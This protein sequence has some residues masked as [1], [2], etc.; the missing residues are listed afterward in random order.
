VIPTVPRWR[1]GQTGFSFED[2]NGPIVAWEDVRN[3]MKAHEAEVD[4][5]RSDID[6]MTDLYEMERDKVSNLLNRLAYQNPTYL[7]E[8]E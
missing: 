3:L 1:I 7:K 4:R 2:P 6:H 5:L 8:I